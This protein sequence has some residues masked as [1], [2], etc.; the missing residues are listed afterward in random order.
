MAETTPA[1]L[2]PRL[3]AEAFGT[4]VLVGAVI[5]TAVFASA[6]TG[7][8]GIA[9]AAG[10]AVVVGVYAVGSIS[11][12]HF[13]PAI[14]LGV[15]ASGRLPWRDVLPY[16]AAQLV[17]GIVASSLMFAIA[18]G[19]SK[20]FFHAA[21]K[22][23]FASNG[24]GEHS[25]GGFDLASVIIV[26]FILTAVFLYVVLSVT[27]PGFTN[28]GFAPL[29]IGLTLTVIHLISIPVSGTSVNPA[30]SIASAIYGADWAR[31]DL[32][33][34]IIVPAVAGLLAG[35]TW[36]FLFARAGVPAK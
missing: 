21:I 27:A 36:K 6:N 31:A 17:G 30:R 25:L 14:T 3:I 19:A 11:G 1:P 8:L 24:Y 7:Y 35:Y 5:G 26:E 4:L 18:A 20:S 33:V 2:L 10:L 23:G 16:I 15:A 12:G 32:W 13:N 29:A 28:P 9:L 34:F 22:N